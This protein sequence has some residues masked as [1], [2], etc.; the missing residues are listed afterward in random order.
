MKSLENY[1]IANI[2]NVE[3]MFDNLNYQKNLIN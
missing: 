2:Y 3:I 1:Q